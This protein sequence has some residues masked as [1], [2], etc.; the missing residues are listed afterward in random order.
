MK[1][2]KNSKKIGKLVLL[3][4]LFIT[5][6]LITILNLPG[7]KVIAQTG[8]GCTLDAWGWSAYLDSF[9]KLGGI[10]WTSFAKNDNDINQLDYGVTVNPD[11]GKM[12]G[13]IWSDCIGWIRFGGLSGFPTGGGTMASDATLVGND[14]KG[15]VRACSVSADANCTFSSLK[16]DAELGGWVGWIALSGNWAEGVTFNPTT[17]KFSG[18]GWGSDKVV[19]WFNFRDVGY[20]RESCEGNGDFE[21][22]ATVEPPPPLIIERSDS[23]G[24]DKSRQLRIVL[25]NGTPQEVRVTSIEE[26]FTPPGDTIN[27]TVDGSDSCRP[28]SECN[29]DLSVD[30]Q[31]RSNGKPLEN[32]NFKILT[33]SDDGTVSRETNFG[34]NIIG[35]REPGVIC[36][37]TPN[38]AFRDQD[39]AWLATPFGGLGGTVSKYVWF[40]DPDSR[41][42]GVE[43]ERIDISG[44]YQVE[45]V[46]NAGVRALD[47]KNLVIAEAECSLQI[48]PDIYFE[49]I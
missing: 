31:L 18:F 22:T 11:N 33:E 15:W 9:G 46:I 39:V 36:S 34:V 38:P 23:S 5:I 12:S 10:G 14:L 43:G 24:T 49:H 29:I 26:I 32:A 30:Y 19:G 7:E 35:T 21:Y 47:D 6:A 1:N 17:E 16:S 48:L 41:V 20:A 45:G 13:Y 2:I 37:A 25:D 28:N 44:G 40:G 4:G 27:L 8:G 42:N 3:G